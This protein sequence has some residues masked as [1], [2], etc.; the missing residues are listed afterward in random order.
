MVSIDGLLVVVPARDEEALIG[1]C[2][3][4]IGEAVRAVRASRPDLDLGVVVVA[5]RC[6]DRTADIA[7]GAGAHVVRTDVGCVGAAR[8]LGVEAGVA[9]LRGVPAEQTWV[10]STDA[11]TRVPLGLAG[12][13]ADACRPGRPARRRSRGAGPRGAGRVDLDAMATPAHLAGRRRSHPRCQPRIQAR[14]LLRS[15]RVVAPGRARGP[16][17]G[18]LAPRHRDLAGCGPRRGDLRTPAR[19]RT[20]WLLGIPTNDHRSATRPRGRLTPPRARVSSPPA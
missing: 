16:T 4:A 10:A 5:D 14:R 15:R 9:L 20:G 3:G 17:P 7:A 6:L 18:R 8:R 19:P 11:D 2:L 13:P 1:R 12:S